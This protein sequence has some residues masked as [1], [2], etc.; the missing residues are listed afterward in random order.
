MSQ[1][2]GGR[3]DKFGNMFEK[4]W[5]VLLSLDVVEGRATAIKWEPLGPEGAGVDCE[6][7]V[8]AGTLTKYQCKATNGT[9]GAWTAAD[10]ADVLSAAKIHLDR[11]SRMR[12]PRPID[13]L[14]VVEAEVVLRA[15]V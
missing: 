15:F 8:A 7:R 12:P 13:A 5:V 11:V 1:L 6:V 9:D 14:R 4:H 10:L 3:A 2:A